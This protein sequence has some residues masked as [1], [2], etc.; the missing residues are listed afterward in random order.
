MVGPG[1]GIAPFRAFL[2]EREATEATGQNWLFFGDRT[3][4]FDYIYQDEIEA[5]QDRGVLHRLDLAWSRD[6]SDKV[7]VQDKMRANGAELFA[8]LEQGGYFFVCGDAYRMAKDVDQALHDIIAE[9]GQLTVAETQEYVAKAEK[10]ETLRPRRLLIF[11]ILLPVQF[12]LVHMFSGAF[13]V[14]APRLRPSAACGIN[15]EHGAV[16]PTGCMGLLIRGANDFACRA[17][18]G[19]DRPGLRCCKF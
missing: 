8:W 7:Y 11:V 5:M 9:H 19:I 12:F 2:E 10:R 18:R 14:P 17:G 3:K 13:Q 16:G 1:T 6:Q 15:S 4:E